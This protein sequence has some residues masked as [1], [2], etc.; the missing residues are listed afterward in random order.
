MLPPFNEMSCIQKSIP[1]ILNNVNF[2][3]TYQKMWF[4]IQKL[5]LIFLHMCLLGRKKLVLLEE[6]LV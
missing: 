6:K 2:K 4:P 1:K 3:N 5:Q